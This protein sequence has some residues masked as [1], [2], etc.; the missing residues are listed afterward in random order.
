MIRL[1][2]DSNETFA[3]NKKANPVK[4]GDAKLQGLTCKVG[5]MPASYQICG[6]SCPFLVKGVF[7]CDYNLMKVGLVA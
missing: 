5:T 2:T 7:W 1:Y 4:A 3:N 6:S